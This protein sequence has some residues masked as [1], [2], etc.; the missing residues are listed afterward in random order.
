MTR[1][2][3]INAIFHGVATTG[4]TDQATRIYIENR[5]SM[6]VYNETV[7]RGLYRH[8]NPL[9]ADKGEEKNETR[10]IEG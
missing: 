5:I 3:A 4:K 6:K 9:P 1:Q 10:I 7:R 8:E 2:Q